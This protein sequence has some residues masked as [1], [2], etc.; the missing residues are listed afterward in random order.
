M[1]ST[2]NT[3]DSKFSIASPN[4]AGG[5]TVTPIADPEAFFAKHEAEHEGKVKELENW[6]TIVRGRPDR[7]DAMTFVG[8]T[9]HDRANNMAVIRH[10]FDLIFHTNM[11]VNGRKENWNC[12]GHGSRWFDY[13]FAGKSVRVA[14]YSKKYYPAT[15][16]WTHKEPY[17]ITFHIEDA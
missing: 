3:T 8:C 10:G 12:G 17:A 16:V 11:K 15:K 9:T 5:Y 4:G 2:T 7:A 6:A 13:E 1:S 14:F